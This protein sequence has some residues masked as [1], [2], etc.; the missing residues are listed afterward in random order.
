MCWALEQPFH[1]LMRRN[2]NE[3]QSWLWSLQ[4]QVCWCVTWHHGLPVLSRWL[5]PLSQELIELRDGRA[6]WRRGPWTEGPGNA[7]TLNIT[8]GWCHS[9]RNCSQ[10][11]EG[12]CPGQ[13]QASRKFP[14][15]SWRAPYPFIKVCCGFFNVRLSV[16]LTRSNTAQW[17]PALA[18]LK[19]WHWCWCRL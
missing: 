10:Q 12:D 13:P 19:L 11:G 15:P 9:G 2:R 14:E 4:K 1:W 8:W 5:V 3:S 17:T 7:P 6:T 18:P 16:A